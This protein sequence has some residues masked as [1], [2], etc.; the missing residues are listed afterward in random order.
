[1]KALGFF[2]VFKLKT[3]GEKDAHEFIHPR[4]NFAES[5][6]MTNFIYHLHLS[7]ERGW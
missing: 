6:R 5:R 1:M 2:P 4:G 7:N 3:L